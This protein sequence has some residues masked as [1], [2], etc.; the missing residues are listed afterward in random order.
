VLCPY[1]SC[2]KKGA[3]FHAKQ[4]SVLSTAKEAKENYDQKQEKARYACSVSALSLN[5][6][7]DDS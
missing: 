4:S 6:P 1:H 7:V 2:N 3:C 5:K